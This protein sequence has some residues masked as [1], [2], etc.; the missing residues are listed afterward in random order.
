MRIILITFTFFI[1]LTCFS[2]TQ[3]DL[4]KKA[5][6]AFQ[7]ADNELNVIY[8]KILSDYKTDT[9]FIKNLKASQRI[10]ITFRDAE[11]KVKYPET[12]SGYYGTVYPMCASIYLE[13]LTEDRI[14]KLKE[15]LDGIEEGDVCIGSVKNKE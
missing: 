10:W 7:T 13:K 12:E 9:L 1:T 8:K 15:W 6:E 11:L 5:N 4:N 2:Q 14:K 3:S